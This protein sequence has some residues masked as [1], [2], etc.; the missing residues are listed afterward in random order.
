MNFSYM[1]IFSSATLQGVTKL[2]MKGPRMIS[3]RKQV[4]KGILQGGLEHT[5]ARSEVPHPL[6]ATRI[7]YFPYPG[8]II[9]LVI[10]RD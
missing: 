6:L 8:F 2:T 3:K 7:V 10:T 5:I 4:L 9:F 1:I